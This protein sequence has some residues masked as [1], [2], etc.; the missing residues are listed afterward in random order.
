MDTKLFQPL[1]DKTYI[2]S[3]KPKNSSGYDEITNKICKTCTSQI[4]HP[5]SYT[6]NQSPSTCANWL[7]SL[8]IDMTQKAE[9]KSSD[10]FFLRLG[11]NKKHKSTSWVNS[12]TLT[13]YHIQ[14]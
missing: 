12:R 7:R 5:L 6:C 11:N 1:R 14:E 13:F 10:N 2:N 4:S 3:L 8:L 9:K